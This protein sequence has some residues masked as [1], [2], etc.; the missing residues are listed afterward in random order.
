M[1]IKMAAKGHDKE[2]MRI[3]VAHHQEEIRKKSKNKKSSDM[4]GE[5]C[6]DGY[7]QKMARAAGASL[8]TTR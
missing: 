7:R 3:A 6:V 8:L 5:A 1:I 2:A 4:D